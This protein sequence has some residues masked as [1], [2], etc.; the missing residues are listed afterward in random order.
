MITH[1]KMAAPRAAHRPWP[2]LAVLAIAL[3]ASAPAAQDPPRAADDSPS[4]DEGVATTDADDW[5]PDAWITTK[6][7]TALIGEVGVHA[8]DV[9]VD[10]RN[11]HVV[12][13]GKVDTVET[14]AQVLRVAGTIEG[15]R[16]VRDL[17]QVVPEAQR[18]LVET[19]DDALSELVT[20]QLEQD[21]RLEDTD[22]AVASVHDGVVLLGGSAPTVSEQLRAVRAAA[23]VPGVER[24]VHD[25]VLEPAAPD[26][27]ERSW[28]LL[29]REVVRPRE[30]T[31]SGRS[32]IADGWITTEIKLALMA[33]D[34]IASLDVN[35]DTDDGAVTLFGVVPTAEARQRADAIAHDADGVRAVHNALEI[36]P[37]ARRDAVDVRDD[38]LVDRLAQMYGRVDR[39]DGIDVE[40]A[41]GVVRLTGD[42]A[43][44]VDR[45]AAGSLALSID[46]TRRVVNELEVDADDS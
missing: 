37:D 20:S 34:D 45:L 41:D 36:V 21:P 15:V 1:P 2:L 11:G 23:R 25:I 35:V 39:F 28:R 24:V 38:A 46:G 9:N 16:D 5:R 40:A 6:V 7:K 33:D 14:H 19:T 3:A 17:V 43:S 30:W 4:R 31:E 42:V 26:E 32:A 18:E 22:I 13:H 44:Q 29:D 12:L 10:T 27:D 8:L